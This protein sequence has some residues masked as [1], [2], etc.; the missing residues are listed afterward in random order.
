MFC[1]Y[2]RYVCHVCHVPL[3]RGRNASV[4]LRASS[5][6]PVG[7]QQSQL[8]DHVQQLQDPIHEIGFCWVWVGFGRMLVDLGMQIEG[9]E[10]LNHLDPFAQFG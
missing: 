1:T 7:A 5:Q 2:V 8:S 6:T 10:V 4:P 3:R 9:F